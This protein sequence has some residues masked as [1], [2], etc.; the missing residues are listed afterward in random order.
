MS[1]EGQVNS[2]K[3]QIT[4]LVAWFVQLI[5]LPGIFALFYFLNIEFGNNVFAQEHENLFLTAGILLALPAI[6]YFK[7]SPAAE[8]RDFDSDEAYRAKVLA[9]MYAGLGLSEVP[10]F[11]GLAGWMSSGFLQTAVILMV[12][13]CVLLFLFK[14]R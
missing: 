6:L 3:A 11:I 12:V 2:D 9:R 13:S 4:T 14:P 1:S 8:R 7:L 5:S 10:F